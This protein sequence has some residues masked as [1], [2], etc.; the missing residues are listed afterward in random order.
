M[1]MPGVELALGLVADPQFGP[2]VVVAAGGVLVEALGDRVTALPPVDRA[3][4]R[5]LIDRLSVRPLLDGVRGA[6][7][8]DVDAV[9]DAVVRLSAVALDLGDLIEAVDVNPLIA[10]PEGC[11]AADA[12][13][14]PRNL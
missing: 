10:G 9:A 11:R 8:A 7:P 1:A 3:G 12:L 6:P 5:G 2:L 14:I 13:L 4:A